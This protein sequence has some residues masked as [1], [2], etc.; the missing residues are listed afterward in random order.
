M[1]RGIPKAPRFGPSEQTMRLAEALQDIENRLAE[2]RRKD[3]ARA[4]LVTFAEK[5]GLSASDLREA[6][7]RIAAREVAD[8][9]ATSDRAAA[10]AIGQKLKAARINAGL[11]TGEVGRKVGAKS[12]GSVS[13]WEKGATMPGPKFRTKLDKLL[14]LPR[15]FWKAAPNGKRKGALNG[16]AHA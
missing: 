6:A 16:T 2:E 5:H 9:P 12:S 11:G 4:L 14:D 8:G 15:D 13:Q 1:P 10:L 7:K 3:K